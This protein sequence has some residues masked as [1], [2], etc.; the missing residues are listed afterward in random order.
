MGSK[1]LPMLLLMMMMLL[2]LLVVINFCGR[3]SVRV[4]VWFAFE[5]WNSYCAVFFAYNNRGHL[6]YDFCCGNKLFIS[7][8]IEFNQCG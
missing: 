5:L 8:V 4:C 1:N 7:F 3:L 6:Y 2:I